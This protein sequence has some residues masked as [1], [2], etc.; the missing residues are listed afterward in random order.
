MVDGMHV[1][2]VVI[3]LMSLPHLICRPQTSRLTHLLLT[4][5][6]AIFVTVYSHLLCASAFTLS[7]VL[8]YSLFSARSFLA[9]LVAMDEYILH[10]G[11]LVNRAA[12]QR[13]GR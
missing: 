9:S 12:R 11:H 5:R 10:S 1:P 13:R 3:L 7:C 2:C 6:Q 4:Y 8:S